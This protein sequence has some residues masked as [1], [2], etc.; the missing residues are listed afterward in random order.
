[1]CR[2]RNRLPTLFLWISERHKKTARTEHSD[3]RFCAT[4]N[5]ISGTAWQTEQLRTQRH[6]SS[7]QV[8][9]VTAGSFV[10]RGFFRFAQTNPLP[11]NDAFHHARH[12]GA[13]TIHGGRTNHS[14]PS[15]IDLYSVRHSHMDIR[16]NRNHNIHNNQD[17]QRTRPAL[18]K[19][20]AEEVAFSYG[21]SPEYPLFP[22]ALLYISH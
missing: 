15:K 11:P 16:S 6:P 7:N 14:D 17:R 18:R 20:S 9:V 21:T 5:S 2:T 13:R 10:H 8:K 3:W 12:G 1:M 19:R 22:N 4:H